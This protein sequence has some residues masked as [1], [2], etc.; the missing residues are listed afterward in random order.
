MTSSARPRPVRRL[1]VFGKLPEP[2]RTKTRLAPSLGAAGAADLYG[3]F[4][5]DTL[6]L[7]RAVPGAEVELWIA[8][9]PRAG[10]ASTAP[11]EATVA[12]PAALAG[13][14]VPVRRQVGADLGARLA[15]AFATSFAEG[16]DHVLIVGS[17]HP[18]LPGAY[19][20]RGFRALRSAQLVIGPTSDGGY[21][22]VGLKRL[23][24]PGAAALFRDIPWSTPEVLRLTRRRAESLDLCRA[25]LPIWYDVD[26]PADLE[27]L[28]RDVAPGT[29]T[30]KVLERLGR[31]GEP[32][33]DR[34]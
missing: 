19:L 11:R 24:W 33:A 15:A 32:G 34:R 27:L 7:A 3:A 20:S 9:P 16:A 29:A 22:A 21:Y 14:G 6:A 18:T 25:E 10:K 31:T 30:R 28:G 2:G 23:A 8:P 13:T 17:D 26:E 12:P 1:L 4:L 5:Q